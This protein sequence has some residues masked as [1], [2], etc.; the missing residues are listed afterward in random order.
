MPASH[1]RGRKTLRS[2]AR[3]LKSRLP[4]STPPERRRLLIQWY[5]RLWRRMF[6]NVPAYAGKAQ[7][8]P[9]RDLRFIEQFVRSLDS[10][11]KRGLR[12][13][14]IVEM[15]REEME[16]APRSTDLFGSWL[17]LKGVPHP[18]KSFPY[19]AYAAL[20]DP[21]HSIRYRAL[22]RV[23]MIDHPLTRDLLRFV[24]LHDPTLAN[25]E[26]AIERLERFSDETTRATLFR[27]LHLFPRSR[28]Q[29][30]HTLGKIGTPESARQLL[31]LY[32]RRTTSPDLRG[33]INKCIHRIS[34]YSGT[35]GETVYRY[36]LHLT[37]EKMLAVL[38]CGMLNPKTQ[39]KDP[40]EAADDLF[41][42]ERQA[43]AM[44][45]SKF[46]KEKGLFAKRPFY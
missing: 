37:P 25:R 23:S 8:P 11:E 45:L 7:L 29:V 13:E 19:L 20:R 26:L 33:Q 16:S 15:G 22:M 32:T 39:K 6:M 2:R 27:C 41:A 3:A 4:D 30:L 1:P 43:R 38:V 40:F 46:I 5:D 36:P 9:G 18:S 14:A 42:L 44:S 28:F 21:I 35:L 31:Y 34:Y 12:I 17:F 24:S 10:Q